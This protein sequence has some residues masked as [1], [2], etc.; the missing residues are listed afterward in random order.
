MHLIDLVSNTCFYGMNH[1]SDNLSKIYQEMKEALDNLTKEVLV[2]DI[3]GSAKKSI[4]NGLLT[5]TSIALFTI[6]TL[7]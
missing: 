5:S 3:T 2:T 4:S 1:I 7:K 6:I